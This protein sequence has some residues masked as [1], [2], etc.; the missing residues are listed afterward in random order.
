LPPRQD[1]AVL[2]AAVRGFVRLDLV[3]A[4]AFAASVTVRPMLKISDKARRSVITVSPGMTG[5]LRLM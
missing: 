5:R 1:D 3:A 2:A 4:L